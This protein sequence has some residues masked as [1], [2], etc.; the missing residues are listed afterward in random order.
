MIYVLPV[1]GLIKK[2]GRKKGATETYAEWLA[3]ALSSE[4]NFDRANGR[5]SGAQATRLLPA[6]IVVAAATT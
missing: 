1:P 4:L 3:E 5:D 6:R 2:L